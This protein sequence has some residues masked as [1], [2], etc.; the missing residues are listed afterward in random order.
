MGAS[1]RYLCAQ[2]LL[3]AL[4]FFLALPNAGRAQQFGVAEQSILTISSERLFTDSEFGRR[5][6][7]EIEAEGAVLA[8]ENERIVEELSREERELTER[9]KEMEPPA[10]RVLAEAFDQKVQTHRE[11][12][13][14][15]LSALNSRGDAARQVFMELARPLLIELMRE[16][17]AGV[18]LER[19]NVFL[20]SNATDI[21]GVAIRRMN[22]AVGDGSKLDQGTAD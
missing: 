2:G 18:I 11:N 4:C 5:I 12:Q 3:L 10:F 1:R 20:S 19:S 16:Y 9:R 22:T 6:I 14:N 17:G 13:K 8:A 7:N 15:K 21:T